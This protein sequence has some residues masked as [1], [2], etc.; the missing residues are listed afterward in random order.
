MLKLVSTS[1]IAGLLCFAS[2]HAKQPVV[3]IK[4]GV[5]CNDLQ[6]I[7][8][9][10][11]AYEKGKDLGVM[12]KYLVGDV[13]TGQPCIY[14]T[15]KYSLKVKLIR[16]VSEHPGNDGIWY[17]IEMSNDGNMYYMLSDREPFFGIGI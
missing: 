9:V 8:K 12:Q 7:T 14:L 16:V 11:K 15:G 6:V 4:T 17:L 10:A 5:V 1:L 13:Y 2:A 3:S